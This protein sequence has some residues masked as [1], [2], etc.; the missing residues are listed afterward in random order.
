MPSSDSVHISGALTEF[1]VAYPVGNFIS[2]FLCP[3]VMVANQFDEYHILDAA[4]RASAR[5][6]EVRSPGSAATL[7]D[8]ATTSGSYRCEG[9]TLRHQI[10]DEQRAN[11]DTPLQPERD[12]VN[13][14]AKTML[15]TQDYLLKVALDASLTATD[16]THEWDDYDNGDVYSDIDTAIDAIEDATSGLTPNAIA[17][18][19]KVW[20]K[21]RNHPDVLARLVAGGTNVVPAQAT[22]Q[23][24]ADLFGFDYVFVGNVNE[25][26]AVQGQTASMSRVWGSDVYI[27]YVEPMPSQMT[28]TCCMRLTWRPFA[29]STEG[30]KVETARAAEPSAYADEIIMG[31]YYDQKVTLAGAG[32][33]LQNRLATGPQS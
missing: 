18:D 13:F 12:G 22:R 23:G 24:F 8:Y 29:G 10:T 4:R 11:A 15:T 20:R 6:D 9:H 14:L 26:V 3:T 33:R 5:H 31:K 32:Y 1:A 19:S 25:N 28:P 7:V 27:M 17:M 2:P 30:F 16:P 21:T